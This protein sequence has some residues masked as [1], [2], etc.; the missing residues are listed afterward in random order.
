MK[1]IVIVSWCLLRS[2][3]NGVRMT[4]FCLNPGDYLYPKVQIRQIRI[5]VFIT[6]HIN[7]MFILLKSQ[8]RYQFPHFITSVWYSIA[9]CQ[10][11][12]LSS[13][14]DDLA[15]TCWFHQKLAGNKGDFQGLV[16]CSVLFMCFVMIWFSGWAAVWVTGA[17][18]AN[19][20]GCLAGAAQHLLSHILCNMYQPI[21]SRMLVDSWG[22]PSTHKQ[23]NPCKHA[24]RCQNRADIGLEMA[25]YGMF[26]W[27][28]YLIIR[29]N[30]NLIN[31]LI[32]CAKPFLLLPYSK[33][34]WICQNHSITTLI[35]HAYIIKAGMS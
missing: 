32:S 13:V 16:W 18:S 15:P 10:I 33:L 12:R 29:P 25:H 7:D 6:Y 1:P 17:S 26:T 11:N 30:T 34:A 19:V 2:R 8:T 24:M 3:M 31:S 14:S 28:P 22:A 20:S 5:N 21:P 4:L 35:Y 9:V 23:I 27:I